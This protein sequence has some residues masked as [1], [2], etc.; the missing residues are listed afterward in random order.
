M[1]RGLRC[2][3]LGFRGLGIKD[4]EAVVVMLHVHGGSQGWRC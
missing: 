1:F 4:V 2:R 3:G